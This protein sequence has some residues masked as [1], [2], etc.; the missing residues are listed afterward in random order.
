MN[1]TDCTEGVSYQGEACA[2]LDDTVCE[3]CQT[4]PDG[5]TRF[6]C[7]GVTEGVCIETTPE[8][9]T[10]VENTTTTTTP[11]P[12]TTTPEPFDPLPLILPLILIPLC[13]CCLLCCL[14]C[15]RKKKKKKELDEKECRKFLEACE[16]YEYRWKADMTKHS[17]FK[18]VAKMVK[19]K[20][21]NECEEHA[22][23]LD[24]WFDEDHFIWNEA[25]AAK[26]VEVGFRG[27]P[28]SLF[29]A[30]LGSL[31]PEDRAFSPPS[32]P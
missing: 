18:K 6:G 32:W 15:R 29:P 13:C 3:V 1:C 17:D 14:C 19:T 23:E 10:E 9:T 26:F 31:A 12:E 11:L 25:D 30:A 22:K 24:H 4:C 28:E 8:N 2:L 5:L 27:A 7:G 20:D 21:A 16:K